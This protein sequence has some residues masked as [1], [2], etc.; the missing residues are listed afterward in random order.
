MS[1]FRAFRSKPLLTLPDARV[2]EDAFVLPTRLGKV[3]VA[4]RRSSQARRMTLRVRSATRDVT[5]TLPARTS[6]S[7][8]HD[9]VRRHVGWIE[10]R[11]ARLPERVPFLPGELIPLRGEG[12]RIVLG[13]GMRGLVRLEPGLRGEEPVIA[14]HGLPEHAPRRVAD[15]LKREA[16]A[17]L[18]A[19][20][21]RHAAALGVSVGRVTIKDTTSRW[22]SRP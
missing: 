20:V 19:A 16:R 15:F 2:S 3:S 6:V 8:A 14:V 11:L 4:I 7:A 10:Q 12:R 21:D 9:F 5:L 1:L 13:D 17:D 22:G 18:L